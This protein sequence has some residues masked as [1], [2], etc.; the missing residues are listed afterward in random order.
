MSKENPNQNLGDEEYLRKHL[1]GLENNK[2]IAPQVQPKEFDSSRVTDLQYL[3]FDA[4]EFPCGIFYPIGSSI[5]IRAAQV[6]EIQSYSMVDD[7]NVYDIIEKMNDMLSSCVRIKY[8]DGSIGSY[9]DIKDGDRF[10]LIF[11]IRELTFQQGSN[12]TTTTNCTCGTEVTLELKRSNFKYH[13]MNKKLAKHFDNV[14]KCFRFETTDGAVYTIAPP[15]IGISKSFTDYIV[16]ENAEKKKP[17]MSFLKIIPF[18]LYD[19]TSISLEDIKK[20]IIKFQNM[21][22]QA[23]QFLN[24]AVEKMNYGIKEITKKCAGCGMEVHTDMLFPDGP[25]AL[26]VVHDAFDQYIKE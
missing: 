20:E 16:K 25:S 26:F 23:F 9:L 13:E 3:A 12:L 22:L 18:T 11:L 5:Q 24:S 2:K 10:F 8:L 17:N 7:T 15:S 14:N 6:R 4:K 19:R 21:S 1:E